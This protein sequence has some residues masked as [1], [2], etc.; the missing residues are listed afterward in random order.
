[1][2]YLHNDSLSIDVDDAHDAYYIAMRFYNDVVKKIK[3]ENNVS[4]D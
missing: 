2:Y 3:G 4:T 1:M